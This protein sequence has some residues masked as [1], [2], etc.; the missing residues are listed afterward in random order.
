MR[1]LDFRYL[2]ISTGG[3]LGPAL[4]GMID[5]IED[6]L[7]EEGDSY[8]AFHQNI[9]GVCGTSAGALAALVVVLGI[10][11]ERRR[12]LLDSVVDMQN[13]FNPDLSL[14]LRNYGWEDGRAL[15][16]VIRKILIAG[17]LSP[18][19]TLGDVQ[20][21]LRRE[22]VCVC[23]DLELASPV[24]LSGERTPTVKVVDALYASCCVPFVFTPIHLDGRLLAD[25]C[26][27]DEQP[28]VFDGSKTLFM[29]LEHSSA[30]ARV[31]TW[32][33]FV[34]AVIRCHSTCQGAHVSRLK[35]AFPAQWIVAVVDAPS[36]N[37]AQTA[38][39]SLRIYRTGYASALDTLLGLPSCSLFRS[40]GELVLGALHG[41]RSA[42]SE[43]A[44]LDAPPSSASPP[45]R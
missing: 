14:L 2:S 31:N 35:E 45:A 36:M 16:S 15:R 29:R 44:P 6:R 17:G 33:T 22:F 38:E 7:N 28:N 19:S 21:L 37:V 12:E 41:F 1:L 39:E 42:V 10:G 4:L 34:G 43:L 23:T 13:H 26:L 9:R 3:T 24:R 40:V 32:P 20:R 8:E 27:V 5:A 25:G 11:K 18:E 30:F